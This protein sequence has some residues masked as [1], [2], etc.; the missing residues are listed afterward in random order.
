MKPWAWVLIG[1]VLALAGAALY[2]AHAKG[3]WRTQLGAAQARSA[4]RDSAIAANAITIDSLSRDRDS[5]AKHITDSI[6]AAAGQREAE[7]QRREQ[8]AKQQLALVAT[9]ADSV[10]FLVEA[11]EAADSTVADQGRRIVLL[12]KDTTIKAATIRDRGRALLL[13]A[14]SLAAITADR[15]DW[16]EKA[17]RKP[18]TEITGKWF[19]GIPKPGIHI[20]AGYSKCPVNSGCVTVGVGF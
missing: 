15:D 17:E 12:V 19:L 11:V 10:P 3:E 4:A 13:S 20:V 14:Q 2:V 18:L 16:K 7:S 9:A 1:A 6:G 8:L 5:T